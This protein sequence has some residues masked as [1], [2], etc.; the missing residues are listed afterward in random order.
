MLLLLLLNILL[1]VSKLFF[2]EKINLKK[3]KNFY[4]KFFENKSNLHLILLY[5]IDKY[6]LI[7]KFK[8][9]HDSWL[10]LYIIPF[11]PK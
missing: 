9:K 5:I 7:S 2:L 3:K 4:N 8:I 6:N 1:N 10:F 11:N